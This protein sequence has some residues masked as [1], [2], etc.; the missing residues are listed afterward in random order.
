MTLHPQFLVD[1]KG[2]QR[3]VLL[4]VKEYRE[5]LECAQDAIDARLI[6]ETKYEPRV[7]WTSVKARRAQRRKS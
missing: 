3:Q 4:T 7:A 2:R 6:D 1:K 5:L